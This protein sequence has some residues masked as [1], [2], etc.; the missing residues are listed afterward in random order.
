MTGP[1][2]F[3]AFRRPAAPLLLLL[4]G[5]A[6]LASPAG[7]GTRVFAGT[8]E[9]PPS[10]GGRVLEWIPGTGWQDRTPAAG[11]GPVWDLAVIDGELWVASGDG[12][13][14][15]LS[16][17]TWTLE[18]RTA[19]TAV[20][21]DELNGRVHATHQRGVDRREDDGT[22]TTVAR[23][24]RPARAVVSSGHDGRPML[25]VGDD[26]HDE[27]W[28]YD[29]DAMLSCGAACPTATGACPAGCHGG[30]C[31]H[32]MAE[33][34]EGDGFL[35]YAGA[36]G[37]LMYRWDPAGRA[38]LRIPRIP[39]AHHVQALAVREG[40]LWAGDANGTLYS[41]PTPSTG[42][43]ATEFDFEDSYPI[44]A[45]LQVE[46]TGELWVGHGGV[47]FGFARSDGTSLVHA[48][49]GDSFEP[50]SLPNA[51]G[52]GVLAFAAIERAVEESVSCDAGAYP[53]LECVGALTPLVLDASATLV[54][55]PGLDAEYLWTG[56]F[57]EASATGASPTV[58]FDGP[59]SHPVL[60]SVTAGSAEDSCA[61]TV[62]VADTIAPD[63]LGVPEDA[64]VACDAVP[65]P[66][67]P[68]AVDLCDADAV[69]ELVQTELPGDC[70]QE[71]EILREWRARDASGNETVARQR[72]TVVD[73]QAP[74]I[75]GVPEDATVPCDAVP[76]PAEP[77]VEDGCDPDPQL[78]FEETRIDGP[79]A[80]TYTLV[81][82]WTATDACGNTSSAAQVIEVVDDTPPTVAPGAGDLACLWPPAHGRACFR[83][84]DFEAAVSLS[85]DCSEP[86]EWRLA[87]CAS[88][89]P[90]DGLG[91]G[92]T[93]DDCLVDPAGEWI[94]VRAERSG[95]VPAGRRYAVAVVATDACGNE[96][97]PAVVG[98]VHVPHDSRSRPR[99]CRTRPSALVRDGE[100][101]PF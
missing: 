57:V 13:V 96:S 86:I 63:I 30:S 68:E 15:R 84:A 69:L 21:V 61:T 99:D 41:S 14:W 11:L 27:F 42:S 53:V 20:G 48:Y 34:D 94:C 60:L 55:P 79:C 6:S 67:E 9:A 51:M 64:T 5:L 80:G 19:A 100:P 101:L 59:G 50:R 52:R 1:P 74:W 71:R 45:L 73:E 82:A 7:A 12:T 37:G 24:A 44:S 38:F 31:V 65:E 33:F 83:R 70:P 2:S 89:Q 29:P 17:S 16:G 22:W 39:G 95:L 43:W 28:V 78:S 26:G 76:E 23:M 93:V 81:R 8:W 62:V 77:S 85:D 97:E 3:P 72:L 54:E 56:G 49:D 4:L 75:V 40:R 36:Y 87:G 18:H 91:D 92:R 58:H 10:S 90:D 47:P 66:A 88:D 98:F 46:S 25:Y 35:A 32:S